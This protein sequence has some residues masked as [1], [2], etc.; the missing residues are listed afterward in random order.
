[1]EP[2]NIQIRYSKARGEPTPP[3]IK[4]PSGL[5]GT[6]RCR[7][8]QRINVSPTYQFITAIA[9]Y[10]SSTDHRH[11]SFQMN[12]GWMFLES[13]SLVEIG[14]RNPPSSDPLF[15]PKIRNTK[16]SFSGRRGCENMTEFEKEWAQWMAI[17]TSRKMPPPP[18]PANLLNRIH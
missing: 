7:V 4:H 18:P 14:L 11:R 12:K 15:A 10:P 9:V 6:R 3:W 16:D 13:R 8:G 1:M 5:S 2:I 17:E